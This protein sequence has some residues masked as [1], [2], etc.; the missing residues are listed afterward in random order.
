[1]QT[2]ED[3]QGLRKV[4]E[5]ARLISIF[6]LAIH[7]YI[8]C[9]RAFESWHWTAAITDRFLSNIARTG[10]FR[11]CLR[12]KLAGLLCLMIS[13]IGIKGKKDEKINWKS[14]TAYLL[15]GLLIY[16]ISILAFYLPVDL[17]LVALC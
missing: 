17:N 12:P 8:S 15:S 9:Y 7:F 2:G 1:M 13:L 16:W 14:I 5:F 6:I 11:N 3:T 10:L 4:V